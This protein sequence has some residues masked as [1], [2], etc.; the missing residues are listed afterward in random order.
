MGITVGLHWIELDDGRVAL[1]LK[2][3]LKGRF[4]CTE[5]TTT[6]NIYHFYSYSA[7]IFLIPVILKEHP[8]SDSLSDQIDHVC[9]T[10]FQAE[11]CVIIDRVIVMVCCTSGI[12]TVTFSSC[13]VLSSE[14]YLHLT[15][16]EAKWHSHSCFGPV[17]VV[18][19]SCVLLPVQCT[20]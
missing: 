2:V 19:S 6:V 18:P 15:C 5:A 7:Q 8:A 3:F 12:F 20:K 14:E 10:V 16:D 13:F 4:L 11:C 17:H 1:W 9:Y